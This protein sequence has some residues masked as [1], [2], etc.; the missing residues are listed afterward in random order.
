MCQECKLLNRSGDVLDAVTDTEV[1]TNSTQ[2]SIT[3]EGTRQGSE[4]QMWYSPLLKKMSCFLSFPSLLFFV[5]IY[6]RM[7]CQLHRLQLPLLRVNSVDATNRSGSD[8]FTVFALHIQYVRE[9]TK[10][11]CRNTSPGSNSGHSK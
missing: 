6:L 9:T 1:N 10:Y 8:L 7:F 4:L 3:E 5:F 2:K 11:V